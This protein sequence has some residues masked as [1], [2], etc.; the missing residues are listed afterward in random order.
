MEYALCAFMS[1]LGRL[2]LAKYAI[3]MDILGPLESVICSARCQINASHGIRNA[4]AL[5]IQ[6][7]YECDRI[8]RCKIKY[9]KFP[10]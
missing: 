9:N 6:R 7:L 1:Q 4:T 3:L 2:H 10:Q 8:L 5:H